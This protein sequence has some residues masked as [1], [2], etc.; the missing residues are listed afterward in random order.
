MEGEVTGHGGVSRNS[1][2]GRGKGLCE[3]HEVRLSLA[4]SEEQQAEASG[5][6]RGVRG[7][8][9]VV[10]KGAGDRIGLSLSGWYEDLS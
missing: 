10:W 6:H 9:T 2:P 7:R 4:V 3:C 8:T 5:W 1:T